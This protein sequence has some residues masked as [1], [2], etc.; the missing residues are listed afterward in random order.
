MSDFFWQKT[1]D[2]DIENDE[3]EWLHAYLNLFKYWSNNFIFCNSFTI[4]EILILSNHF[5]I[6]FKLFLTCFFL[7]FDEEKKCCSFFLFLFFDVKNWFFDVQNSWRMI[8]D[9]ELFKLLMLE[10][11]SKLLETEI[12]DLNWLKFL[13]YDKFFMIEIKS[14]SNKHDYHIIFKAEYLI[15]FVD[16]L[17]VWFNSFCCLKFFLIFLIFFLK[18]F[19]FQYY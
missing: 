16:I 15:Y 7:S 4:N 19:D 12:C 10:K 8:D 13:M 3:T 11:F 17:S 18:K 9:W 2:F 5:N 6:C 14:F 1:D